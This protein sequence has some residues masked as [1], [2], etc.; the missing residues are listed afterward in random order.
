MTENLRQ[1]QLDI[2]VKFTV[3]LP[4][5]PHFSLRQTKCEQALRPTFFCHQHIFHDQILQIATQKHIE[6]IFG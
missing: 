3:I 1:I 5:F 6:R 2:L 4:R